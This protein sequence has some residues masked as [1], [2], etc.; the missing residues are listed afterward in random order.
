[1]PKFAAADLRRLGQD[2]FTCVGV[3]EDEAA[4]VSDHMVESGL[5]GHDSHSV[6]RFPQYT[7]MVRSGKVTPGAPL[8]ILREHDSVVQVNGNWNYGPVTATRATEL[9]IERVKDRAM[10]I[11]TVRGCNHVAR[12]GRFVHMVA[13][14]EHLI[15]L[16]CANGHGA[17][18]AVAPF[19]GRE[20][21]L[22]TNPLAVGIPTGRDWPIVLDMTTS[23]TSGGALR[24]YRNRNEPVPDGS[25]VDGHGRQTTDVEDYYNE[26]FGAMLPLGFPLV[27][28]KGTGLAVVIDILSG[29]LSGAGCSQA[30]P[31]E[32]G[33]ALFL[34]ILDIRAFRELTDFHDEV[35]RFIDFLK[36]S[37][38]MEGFSEVMLPGEKSH[39]IRLEREAHGMDVD[40][41]AW[42]QISELAGELGID[43]PKPL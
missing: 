31:P 13:Q 18:L 23:M 9:A 36:S 32:S 38:P 34:A 28:H 41:T 8:E 43:L 25:I 29:A 26:P 42:S 40:D 27:G 24:E 20:R 21:R 16:M 4:L 14:H 37:E 2:L 11:V 33:N 7:E 17:D 10:S 39:R 35:D 5:L 3:P 30:D 6:L 15:G 19:G 22:P 1:M 12:L